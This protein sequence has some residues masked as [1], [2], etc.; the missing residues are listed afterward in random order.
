MKVKELIKELS[1]LD[2]EEKIFFKGGEYLGDYREVRII[3]KFRSWTN[4]G[5]CINDN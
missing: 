2:Q 1:K 4:E 3:A 5:Y